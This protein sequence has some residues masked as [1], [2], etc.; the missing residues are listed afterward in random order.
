[1]RSLAIAMFGLCACSA[2]FGGTDPDAKPGTGTGT[3]DSDAPPGPGDPDARPGGPTVDGPQ[4]TG[5]L[6]SKPMPWTEDVFGMTPSSQSST[7]ITGLTNLGGWGTGGFQ[8]D[9]SILIQTADGS[10]PTVTFTP[11]DDAW[12][13]A[14]YGT[15]DNAEF[16]APDC[17]KPKMPMPVGGAVEGETGYACTQDGDCHL[18]IVDQASRHLIEMWRADYQGGVLYGGCVADWNLDAAYDQKLLRGAGCSSA[19]AGGFPITAML[20]TSD[21]VATGQVEHALRFILPNARIRNG[22]YIAPGTHSTFPTSGP[23]DAPPYGVRFRLRADY[24]LASLP[25]DGARTLAVALQHYGMFLADGGTVPVTIASDRFSTVKWSSLGVDEQSLSALEPSDFEVIEYG[26][27]V[28]YK[29]NT[30]CT[31]TGL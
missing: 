9:I 21:E 26:T 30:D 16:Y 11:K 3:G 18:L 6:F 14:K 22:I 23:A 25:S 2:R 10:T 17:D 1:M 5:G 24:P 15:P 12:S 31:R 8:M 19:D 29:A 27:P 7:I 4:A 20:A 28:D 13:Q